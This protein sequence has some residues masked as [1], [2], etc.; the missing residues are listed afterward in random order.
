MM[1]QTTF[2]F[3]TIGLIFTALLFVSCSDDDESDLDEM[4][5]ETVTET[6]TLDCTAMTESVILEENGSLARLLHPM[7]NR[8]RRTTHHRTR[9]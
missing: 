5:T 9:C 4:V 7:Q 2:H 3:L 6:V 1:K 8:R